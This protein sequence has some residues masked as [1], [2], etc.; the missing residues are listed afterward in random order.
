M[1]TAAELGATHLLGYPSGPAATPAADAATTAAVHHAGDNIIDGEAV[2][3]SGATASDLD[4][5]SPE[6]AK[7]KPPARPTFLVTGVKKQGDKLYVVFKETGDQLH[8][9]PEAVAN[10]AHGAK[11]VSVPVHVERD[12]DGFISAMSVAEGEEKL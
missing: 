3:D 9:I 2:T 1:I 8:P 7:P 11:S 6:T 10:T 5:Y 4:D 12:T